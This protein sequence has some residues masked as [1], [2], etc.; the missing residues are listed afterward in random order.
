MQSLCEE[1]LVDVAADDLGK[2]TIIA[3]ALTLIERSLLDQRP[4]FLVTAGRRG[5]G[6]T[7][8][9]IMLIMAVT[10]SLPAAAGVQRGGTA[11]GAAGLPRVWPAV[12]LMG[13]HSTRHADRLPAH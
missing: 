2:C 6:K 12:Y 4:A 11:Q 7:T 10:G 9:L 1:W 13:Q 8:T 3:A 5:N